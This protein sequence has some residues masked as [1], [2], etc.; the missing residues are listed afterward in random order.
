L[1]FTAKA[2]IGDAEFEVTFATS[3]IVKRKNRK[4]QRIAW[5]TAECKAVRLTIDQIE[6]LSG[7]G[8]RFL[9][10]PALKKERVPIGFSSELTRDFV[11]HSFALFRR[12]MT[13]RP[14]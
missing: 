1:T 3:I 6:L 14:D 12:K 13:G 10:I 4:E 11:V 7:D 5:E 2:P 8:K 9:L